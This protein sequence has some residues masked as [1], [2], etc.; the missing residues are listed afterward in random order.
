MD[1]CRLAGCRSAAACHHLQQ[2]PRL[3]S[4]TVSEH[5]ITQVLFDILHAF[6]AT[7]ARGGRVKPA[8]PFICSVQMHAACCDDTTH[9]WC[10]YI[11]CQPAN[12]HAFQLTI[13]VTSLLSC[14][15]TLQRTCTAHSK[16]TSMR[17]VKTSRDH[18][19]PL[20]LSSTCP[21]ALMLWL[22]R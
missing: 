16:S 21:M 18:S 7:S 13:F 1:F 17:C 19:P 11:C 15:Q 12:M 20:L 8:M 22:S 5:S 10:M 9:V 14:C 4:S 6:E 2:R 3:G